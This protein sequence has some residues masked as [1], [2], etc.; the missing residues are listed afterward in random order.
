MKFDGP[1]FA[2]GWLSTALAS[3]SDKDLVAL[4]RTVAI[5]EYPT[6]VR[7]IATDRLILLTCW[8][9]S[10]DAKFPRE[11]ELDEAPDRT[12]IAADSDGRGKSLLGYVRTLANRL[13]SDPSLYSPGEITLDL[14]FDVRLPAGQTG[15]DQTLE[16]ME[17]KYV[18]LEV[19]DTEQV[20]LQT[21]E[22]T[23]PSW[24]AILSGFSP[25]TTKVVS[26]YPERL[27]RLGQLSKLHDGTLDWTFGGADRAAMV[28]VRDSEPHVQGVVMPVRWVTEQDPRPDDDQDEEAAGGQPLDLRTASG[29][30]TV[31]DLEAA[32]APVNGDLDLLR[33]AADLVVST[34]FSS[35]AMLQRKLKVGFAKAGRLMDLLESNGVVGPLVGTRARAVLVKPDD[36]TDEAIA[37]LS[38][39]ADS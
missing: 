15:D 3:S 19:P 13:H 6:G 32:T 18:V 8:V 10:L 28:E 14:K 11:P 37:S 12:V 5:E 33:Q 17:P 1:E 24:R 22:T 21:I 20:Y 36:L 31:A 7:L 30:I 29:V 16:G 38:L 27:H 34:Q 9:A 23:Y 25:E 2:R 35:T 39:D 4:N 26:F